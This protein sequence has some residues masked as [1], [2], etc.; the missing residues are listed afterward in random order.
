MSAFHL[1][2]RKPDGERGKQ[3]RQQDEWKQG[4]HEMA[5][6]RKMQVIVGCRMQDV[7]FY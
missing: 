7:L 4:V 5:E 3:V 2:F 6:D 1:Q